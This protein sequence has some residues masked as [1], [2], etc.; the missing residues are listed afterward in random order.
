MRLADQLHEAAA[1]GSEKKLT[2]WAR[3]AFQLFHDEPPRER[4]M[5]VATTVGRQAARSGMSA[6][7]VSRW[8]QG[9]YGAVWVRMGGLNPGADLKE[10]R[11]QILKVM[12]K[13]EGLD[14][15]VFW[16]AVAQRLLDRSKGKGQDDLHYRA[17]LRAVIQGQPT[18]QLMKFP[19]ARKAREDLV[20]EGG[21]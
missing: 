13:A 5:A 9:A 16:K 4:A 15:A 14:E 6:N 20:D 18:Q 11:K 8:L 17:Y 19:G 10:I 12:P 2:D 21:R 7:E 3:Q 1:S